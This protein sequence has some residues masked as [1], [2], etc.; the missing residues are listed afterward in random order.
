MVIA[1]KFLAY[2]PSN[3]LTITKQRSPSGVITSTSSST[4]CPISARA[5]GE[6]MLINFAQHRF[7]RRQQDACVEAVH[8]DYLYLQRYP[9]GEKYF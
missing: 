4:D 2:P 8:L 1:G 5:I 7:H 9:S 3:Q 6:S